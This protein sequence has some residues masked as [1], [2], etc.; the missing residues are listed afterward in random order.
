[1]R[2]KSRRKYFFIFLS[3]LF[4][5]FSFNLFSKG[6]K[7]HKQKLYLKV[8]FLDV[9][10]G[11]GAV[12]ITPQK[13]VVLIDA[14]PGE[15]SLDNF[16][17]GEEVVIP[18]L[19][20]LGVK[21]IDYVVASHAHL[22]HIGGLISVFREFKIG[23]VYDSGFNYPSYTYERFLKVIKA[24]KIKYKIIKRGDKLKW[25]KYLKIDV[26]SP[27]PKLFRGGSD[28]NDN[29]IVLKIKYNN[30]SILFTGD[31]ERRAELKM[32]SKYKNRLEATVLKV[33]HHGSYTSTVDKF[34]YYVLPEV[35]VI[36]CGRNNRFGHPHKSVLRRLQKYGVKIYRTDLM[37]NIFFKT[38]G[39]KYWIIK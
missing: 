33:G 24:K 8:W 35:A 34:L 37:G 28:C 10:Q 20:S 5:S 16:D 29:S 18:F 22:D 3:I 11:D 32:I 31:A 36:S 17:A 19:H 1:V 6:K 12:L 7:V 23:V 13:K 30:I 15:T 21:K 39:K 27:P 2:I 26:L 9:G 25:D 4:L 38:D 14:G